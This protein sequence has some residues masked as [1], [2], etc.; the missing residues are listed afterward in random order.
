MLGRDVEYGADVEPHVVGV[1]PLAGGVEVPAGPPDHVGAGGQG[2][3]GVLDPGDGPAA[4]AGGLEP[5]DLG[6]GDE[7]LVVGVVFRRAVVEQHVVAHRAGRVSGGQAG[8]PGDVEVLQPPQVQPPPDE[9]VDAADEG[10]L[11]ELADAGGHA[12]AEG[13]VLDVRAALAGNRDAHRDP[14]YP[15]RDAAAGERRVQRGGSLPVSR[16]SR[17]GARRPRRP[18]ATAGPAG[19]SASGPAPPASAR[20]AATGR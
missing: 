16:S 19:R 18:A 6:Q 3:L 10:V 13:E 14:A 5:V 4:V 15:C 11:G 1:Q 17:T 8:D 20:G 7:P 12:A 9:R 2:G